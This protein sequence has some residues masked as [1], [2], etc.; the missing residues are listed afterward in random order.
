LDIQLW[1]V[2]SMARPRVL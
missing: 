2:L 1:A